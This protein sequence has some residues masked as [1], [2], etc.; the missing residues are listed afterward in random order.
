M[1]GIVLN[2]DFEPVKTGCI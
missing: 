1:H 2:L